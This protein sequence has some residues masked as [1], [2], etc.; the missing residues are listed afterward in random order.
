MRAAS[1]TKYSLLYRFLLS[2]GLRIGEA[3]ALK[4]SDFDF[5][6]GIVSVNK[7]VVFVNGEKIEQTPKSDAGYRI[8]PVPRSICD[9]IKC[10]S[11]DAIFPYSYNAVRKATERIAKETGL[12]VT[13]H[14]LRHTY[15]TRL[16]EGNI[17]P[18]LKQYLLGHASLEVTQN[19]YT[20]TTT[21][22]LES[23]SGKIQNVFC[24]I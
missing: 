4:R 9:E 5:E 2:T 23:V 19:I 18:K 16:E 10:M 12:N 13:L 15:A 22:Y 6:K 20:D 17:Q 14:I 11:G 24:G 8:V 7:N 21:E 1:Q 3:L